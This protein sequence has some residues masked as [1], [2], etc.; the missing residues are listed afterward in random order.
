MTA[1]VYVTDAWLLTELLFEFLI[2]IA[3]RPGFASAVAAWPAGAAEPPCGTSRHL[4]LSRVR[5]SLPPNGP[6]E[7]CALSASG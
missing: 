3:A 5:A 6:L 7:A 1:M 4:G 2:L